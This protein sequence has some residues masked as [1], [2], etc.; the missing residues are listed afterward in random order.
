MFFSK[1][2][3]H[4]PD[5][6]SAWLVGITIGLIA[7]IG[8]FAIFFL[9]TEIL[10]ILFAGVFLG[11]A[12]KPL[13]LRL[14][15]WGIPKEIGAVLVFFFF[16]VLVGLFIGLAFP[17]LA[18]QT[19]D[20][21]DIFSQGYTDLYNKLNESPNVVIHQFL[22]TLP[23]NLFEFGAT[24]VTPQGDAPPEAGM[25]EF[26]GELGQMLDAALGIIF[27]FFL[28]IYWAVEEE[29]FK[30][31]IVLLSKQQQSFIQST[32]DRLEKRISHYLNGLGLL[33]L[34][35][36]GAS[37][38]GYLLLGLP[39]ALVLAVFAGIM[40]AVPMIGP[41]IG[42]I[43]AFIIGL[44]ISP[45]TAIAV[46]VLTMVIQAVENTWLLS[47]IMG[48]STGVPPFITLIALAA[49]STLFGLAGA[50]LAIPI[51]AVIQVLYES[52]IEYRR[53]QVSEDFGRDWTSTLR[54]QI[55]ELVQD[56]STTPSDQQPIVHSE[57]EHLKD[58]LESI[59]VDLDTLLKSSA[60]EELP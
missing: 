20:L 49:F 17:L 37:F 19:A 44:S 7:L 56:I 34:I 6:P 58:S 22:R 45:G 12:I 15:R 31:I 46:V 57:V 48:A 21:T 60:S 55:K 27:V 13:V 9:H 54:Y 41:T 1:Q 25:A 59:A 36:G 40:E 42:A 51:A 33:S 4:I 26:G 24:T 43:P 28:A 47:R 11:M 30:L 53:S 23:K 39:Y 52:I 18:N 50:L 14:N 29:R 5:I 32:L 8:L 3:P 10:L 16:L 35:I 2:K 38:V